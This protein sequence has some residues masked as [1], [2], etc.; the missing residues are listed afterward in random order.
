[1]S[2]DYKVDFLSEKT[3]AEWAGRLRLR[4]KMTGRYTIDIVDLIERVLPEILANK[5]GLKI[6]FFSGF[7]LQARRRCPIRARG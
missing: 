4:A 6:E 5:G 1:M 3:L 7:K 2:T